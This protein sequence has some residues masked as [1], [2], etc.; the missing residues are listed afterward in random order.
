MFNLPPGSR[1]RGGTYQKDFH[2]K[3]LTFA[4]KY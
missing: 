2:I 3:V 4:Q 1:T